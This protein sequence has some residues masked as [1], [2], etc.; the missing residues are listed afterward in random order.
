VV[1]RSMWIASFRI[2][3]VLAVLVPAPARATSYGY[4]AWEFEIYD[5]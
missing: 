1:S 4:S 3:A 5:S 2:R